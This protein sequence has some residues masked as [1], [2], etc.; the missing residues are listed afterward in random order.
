[1]SKKMSKKICS[2]CGK[3]HLLSEYR[4]T[5]DTECKYCRLLNNLERKLKLKE[6]KNTWKVKLTIENTPPVTEKV[7][8]IRRKKTCK[9]T[10]DPFLSDRNFLIRRIKGY[11]VCKEPKPIKEIQDTISVKLCETCGKPRLLNEYRRK[12]DL[13]CKYCKLTK[14]KYE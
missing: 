4:D 5:E 10:V 2:T 14:V 7:K 9:K 11:N 1:M 8:P 13:E 12:E 3:Y 6:L